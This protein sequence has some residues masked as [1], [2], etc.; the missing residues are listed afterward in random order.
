MLLLARQKELLDLVITQM[1]ETQ[2]SEQKDSACPLLDVET[3]KALQRSKN[4]SLDFEDVNT[5]VYRHY[6]S[7]S[8]RGKTQSDLSGC[9]SILRKCWKYGRSTLLLIF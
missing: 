7:T 9:L 8:S 1:L 5:A 4:I 2:P 3:V 6:Q